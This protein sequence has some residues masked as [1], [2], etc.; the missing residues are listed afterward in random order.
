MSD[1]PPPRRP[2]RTAALFHAGLAGVV[3]L[4]A[5][6]TGGDMTRAL[7]IAAG[8]FVI[9]T[10]WSWFRFRQ[11]EAQSATRADRGERGGGS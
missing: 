5:G 9:A 11:R 4:F 3:L 7:A 10:G 8:Y 1:L 2:D 6:L